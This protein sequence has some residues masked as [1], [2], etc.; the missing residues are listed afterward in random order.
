MK[1][2]GP[3]CR[4][5]QAPRG[6]VCYAEFL[7]ELSGVAVA[8]K[9]LG[10]TTEEFFRGFL[11]QVRGFIREGVRESEV[12]A[13]GRAATFLVQIDSP[14]FRNALNVRIADHE[15]PPRVRP[16]IWWNLELH[17]VY[18]VIRIRIRDVRHLEWQHYNATR[19]EVTQD[20]PP[21]P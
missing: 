7:I 4:G 16:N 3:Q 8:R 20:D 5:T 13:S 12:E 15:H 14:F 18:P 17:F 21:C 9:G 10:K 1:D 11:K 19:L 6:S 2:G